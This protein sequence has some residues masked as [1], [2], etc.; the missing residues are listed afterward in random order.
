ML[1]GDVY[2]AD[3][4]HWPTSWRWDV[5]SGAAWC[6]LLF[7]RNHYLYIVE[8]LLIALAFV[9]AF[10]GVL[11]R[12]LLATEWL[13]ILG[14]GSPNCWP[15]MSGLSSG[16]GTWSRPRSR[17]AAR[18]ASGR[19]HAHP[20]QTLMCLLDVRVV[21][22]RQP[23]IGCLDQIDQSVGLG[24]VRQHLRGRLATLFHVP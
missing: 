18:S 7:P 3:M 15:R 24:I 11:L 6:I 20:H 17:S 2:V 21:R 4:M 23:A 19:L 5:I 22:Q 14:S 12:R 9:G 10:R 8:P 1:L 13:A 16:R